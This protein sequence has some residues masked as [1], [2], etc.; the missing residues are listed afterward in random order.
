[1]FHAEPEVRELRMQI[2][3]ENSRYEFQKRDDDRGKLF[4]RKR[5]GGTV[6]YLTSFKHGWN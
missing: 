5:N 6:S 4:L 3:H 1:M 2:D